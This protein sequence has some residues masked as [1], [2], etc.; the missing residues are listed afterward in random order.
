MY[1][2]IADLAKEVQETLALVN[3]S[4]ALVNIDASELGISPLK[5]RHTDGSYVIHKLLCAKVQ[6]LSTLALLKQLEG[7]ATN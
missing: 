6:A 1:N 5:L 2:T 7:D 3:T 4:I